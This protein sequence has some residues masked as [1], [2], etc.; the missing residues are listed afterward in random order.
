VCVC[1]QVYITLLGPNVPTRIVKTEI[2]YIVGASRNGLISILN[3]IF[4]KM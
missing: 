1:V 4:L 2:T 3:Y